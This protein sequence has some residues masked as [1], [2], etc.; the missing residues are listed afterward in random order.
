MWP[1]GQKSK[2]NNRFIPAVVR[3][4]YDA[5]QTTAE[6]KLNNFGTPD[7]NV[8]VLTSYLHPLEEINDLALW[9]SEDL[10][11]SSILAFS[12]ASFSRCSAIGSL[13]RSMFSSF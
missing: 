1:F 9:V 10:F 2:N 8:K 13:R 3:A 6:N 4:R 12:E 7:F 5:A 11:D